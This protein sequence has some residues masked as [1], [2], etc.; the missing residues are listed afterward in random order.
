MAAQQIADSFHRFLPTRKIVNDIY[1]QTK[2][3]LEAV[4]MYAFRD[5]SVTMWHH[6]LIMKGN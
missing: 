2:V 1:D 6:H 5:S 3:K 4:P